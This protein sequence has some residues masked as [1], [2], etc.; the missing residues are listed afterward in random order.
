MTDAPRSSQSEVPI[1]VTDP[2]RGWAKT[3]ARLGGNAIPVEFDELQKNVIN[4]I[5]DEIIPPAPGWPAPSQVRIV[6]FVARYVTPAGEPARYYPFAG[7]DQFK[8]DLDELGQAFVVASRNEKVARLREL[9]ANGSEFFGQIKALTY[10]GYYAQA[11]VVKAIRE[12]LSAGRDYHGPP[13][14]YGYLDVTEE[15]G[16]TAFPHGRGSY[17]PTD[18]VRAVAI[19]E[20][21]RVLYTSTDGG[22]RR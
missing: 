10:Y 16:D 7:E 18:Q 8:R 3:K 17:V 21:L 15:W 22:Y 5:A 1:V 13:Q 4:A 12:N 2:R 11:E 9:E 6:D 19:P 14:P 20:S